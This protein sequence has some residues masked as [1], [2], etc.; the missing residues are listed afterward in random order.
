MVAVSLV[1]SLMAATMLNT[2]TTS[3]VTSRRISRSQLSKGSL[4]FKVKDKLYVNR[5]KSRADR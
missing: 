5:E 1:C 4:G 3:T 2:K